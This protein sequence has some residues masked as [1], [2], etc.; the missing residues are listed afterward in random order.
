MKPELIMDILQQIDREIVLKEQL[1]DLY[2]FNNGVLDYKEMRPEPHRL[3]CDSVERGGKTQLHLWPRGHFK[4]TM[5]T[6]GYTLL[7]IAK[8]PNIRILIANA[9]LANSKS[10]LREIKGHLERNEKLRS[11]IG[12]QVSKDEKW[13]ETEIIVKGRTK[14]LKEPTIQCAGVGQGLASQHYDLIIG[15]D[16]VNELTVTTPEQIQKT[17]DWYKMAHSLLEPDGQT[18]L[19]GTRYHFADIYGWIIKE[20]PDEYHPEIHSVYNED[21]SL[22]FPSRF[23]PEIIDRL[24]RKQGSYMFNCQYL[25]NPVDD[26]SAKFKKS[27]IKYLEILP[28]KQFYTTMTVDRAYS[29]NKTADYTGISVRKK[30]QENFRYFPYARRARYTEGELINKIFDLRKHY[31]VDRIGI[32]QNA[33]KSTL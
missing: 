5:I 26:E 15:D 1:G 3:M 22:I 25:N 20:F 14:N 19:I 12:D 31:G 10:F 2:S 33:F 16:L 23:T 21:G 11:I 29:L 17:I 28:D 13:T 7:S 8:N 30:D 18:I 4:S 6:V 32:E 27:Q 9:T 24:R